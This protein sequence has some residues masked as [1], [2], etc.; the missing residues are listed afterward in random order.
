MAPPLPGDGQQRG[1][2]RVAH[3]RARGATRP[4]QWQRG[5]RGGAA[6]LLLPATAGVGGDARHGRRGGHRRGQPPLPPPP[7]PRGA[8]GG[9]RGEPWRGGPTQTRGWRRGWA[10]TAATGCGGRRRRVQRRPLPSPDGV[11]R[12]VGATERGCGWR[13]AAAGWGGRREVGGAASPPARAAANAVDR[14]A[15]H[16]S[17]DRAVGCAARRGARPPT[18]PVASHAAFPLHGVCR[19]GMYLMPSTSLVQTGP[20]RFPPPPSTV[21]SLLSGAWGA[22]QPRRRERVAM[23]MGLDCW[24]RRYAHHCRRRHPPLVGL[25]RRRRRA[26]RGR[27]RH[28]PF[29]GVC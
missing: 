26:P 16:A 19:A 14:S 9:R 23:D 21:H 4:C 7:P 12:A 29:V 5:G 8:A 1:A 22:G 24:R 18:S 2:R 3:P 28:P 15:R 10:C 25:C 13:L 6:P 17:C 11:G 27:R 20:R